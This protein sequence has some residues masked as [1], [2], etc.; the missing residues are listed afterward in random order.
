MLHQLH[1]I[2]RL[3]GQGVTL[4]SQW[5]I[6]QSFCSLM[7]PESRFVEMMAEPEC[8]VC[9]ANDS[10]KVKVSNGAKIRNQYNQVPHLTQDTKGKVTNSQNQNCVVETETFG[11]GSIMMFAGIS[12]HTKTPIVRLQGAVNAGRYQNDI[13]LPLV[14]PHIRANRGMILAQDDVPCHSARTTQQ[15]LR[16]NNVRLLGHTGQC[17]RTGGC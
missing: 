13:L 15:L 7:K 4:G 11:G 17:K 3:A 12:M 14:I 10:I 9:V 6:G 8:T 2:A 5:Q 1:Q 16:A